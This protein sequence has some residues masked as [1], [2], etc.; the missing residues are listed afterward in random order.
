MHLV[1][2][3]GK[4]LWTRVNKLISIVLVVGIAAGMTIS[5]VALFQDASDVQHWTIEA[6]RAQAQLN[7]ESAMLWREATSPKKG[8]LASAN[9]LIEQT[10]LQV[11]LFARQPSQHNL[12]QDMN[13]VLRCDRL[14]LTAFGRGDRATAIRILDFEESSELSMVNR[15][16]AATSASQDAAARSTTMIADLEVLSMMAFAALMT[17]LLFRKFS[18]TKLNSELRAAQERAS[19]QARFRS[20][21]V[22][23]SDVLVV[24]DHNFDILYFTPSFE[25]TLGHT[26][27]TLRGTSFVSLLAEED[28]FMVASDLESL[29]PGASPAITSRWRHLDGT[30]RSM[31]SSVA[32]LLE[33][34]NVQAIVI[35]ARD[36]S[37]RLVLEEQLMR[38]A[39]HDALTGLPNRALLYER[40]GSA[41]RRAKPGRYVGL[42]YLDLDEFKS[43]NDTHGH[44]GGDELLRGVADRLVASVGVETT[45]A[46]LAGDEFAIVYENIADPAMLEV[47][48]ELLV[49]ALH[50]P[51]HLSFGEQAVHASM[52]AVLSSEE[53]IAEDELL[54]RA[55]VA[56]YGAKRDARRH[57]ALFDPEMEAALL[58][59]IAIK[60][61]LKVAIDNDGLTVY[62]QPVVDLGSGEVVGVEALVRWIHPERGMLPPVVFVPIAEESDLIFELG[63]QVLRKACLQMAEWNRQRPH[64]PLTLNVNLSVRE[65]EQDD[66]VERVAEVLTESGIDPAVL[67]LELTETIL[68]TH[69]ERLVAAL[70]GLRSLG[71]R[72]AID[73]FGTGY[74]SLSYLEN[75]PVDSLKIDKSFTDHLLSD[76]PPVT[77][78]TIMQLG[79]DL[80]LK[81][82]AEGI[83]EARQA[84]TLVELGCTYGQGFHFAKPLAAH[85]LAPR[86]L[87]GAGGGEPTKRFR[88]P[89]GEA[90]TEGDR[91]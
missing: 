29:R 91:P 54:R 17:V 11:G 85:E 2:S 9:A 73:D 3:K 84:D 76:E 5:V 75:L 33:D 46:R 70:E 59:R 77:L 8:V 24:L 45:V 25:R 41:L 13:K 57:Y 23:S 66:L 88:A 37:E 61:D 90:V 43:V 21:V 47:Q 82:V 30:Y 28:R 52:G 26:L 69:P 15:A 89:A 71:L 64:A 79:R 72:I 58:E 67:T 83:E 63:H 56:M 22:N 32:N 74:S 81:I 78:R 87:R 39:F 80:R 12:A 38:S 18:F 60:A 10:Q 68:M 40:L 16:V 1:A 7:F 44:A 31:E 42:I 86:I 36:V 62:Y 35:N 20:V 27:G 6:T 65:F 51:F 19:A 49:A 4:L 14:A 55:D 48:C 50:T 34:P 53:E